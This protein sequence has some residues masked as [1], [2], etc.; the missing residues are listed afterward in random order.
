MT[1]IVEDTMELFPP[2]H[3]GMV[4][5]ARQRNAAVEAMEGFEPEDTTRPGYE[6]IRVDVGTTEVFSAQTYVISTSV[7][8]TLRILGHDG[9]RQ[10]AV[11]QTLDQ[12]IVVATSQAAAQDNRNVNGGT[13][14]NAA[15]GFV[16]PLNG[17]NPSG[18]LEVKG[19]GEVWV[20]ATSGTATRVCVWA[21]SYANSSA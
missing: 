14:G 8:P 3:G 9:N 16:L 4:H 21:E 17:T 12:P 6:A 15:G 7:N 10:R 18:M 1:D 2:K 13:A 5:E 19:S 11:I 20:A